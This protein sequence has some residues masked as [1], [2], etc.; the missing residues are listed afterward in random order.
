MKKTLI[1]PHCG[2]NIDVSDEKLEISEIQ[3][4]ESEQIEILKNNNIELG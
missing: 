4:S 3:L 1:C 2:E